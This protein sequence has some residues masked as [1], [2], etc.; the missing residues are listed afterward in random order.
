MFN[1]NTVG[2]VESILGKRF[3]FE[4]GIL[5]SGDYTPLRSTPSALRNGCITKKSPF[6]DMTFDVAKTPNSNNQPTIK[7]TQ[8]IIKKPQLSANA[9]YL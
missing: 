2:Y 4:N 6:L 3:A 7:L 8:P 9:T 5:S 1:K